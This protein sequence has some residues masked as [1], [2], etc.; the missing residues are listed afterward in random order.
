MS[1]YVSLRG[2]QAERALELYAMA[3]LNVAREQAM[4][5]AGR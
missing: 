4:Q 3:R 1:R 2:A 5:E